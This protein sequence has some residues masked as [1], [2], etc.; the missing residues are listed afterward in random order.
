MA[1]PAVAASVPPL[2]PFAVPLPPFYPPPPVAPPQAIEVYEEIRFDLIVS[3]CAALASSIL[4]LLLYK[5]VPRVRRTPGWLMLRATVCEAVVSACFLAFFLYENG[6]RWIFHNR[7]LNNTPVLPLILLLLVGFE[8]MAHAWR[9]LIFIEIVAVYRNPFAP[10]RFHGLYPFFVLLTGLAAVFAIGGATGLTTGLTTRGGPPDDD[11]AEQAGLMTLGL[12][13][14]FVPFGLFVVVGFSLHAAVKL[15][16]ASANSHRRATRDGVPPSISFLAR[17]RVMRHGT[18]YLIWHGGQLCVALALV[19]LFLDVDDV[20]EGEPLSIMWHAL[21]VI[22][23]GRPALSLLGWLVIN[24]IAYLLCGVCSLTHWL[25]DWVDLPPPRHPHRPHL[26]IPGIRASG[27]SAAAPT[28]SSLPPSTPRSAVSGHQS[29]TPLGPPVGASE[30]VG[31]KEEMRFE[32]LYV[33]L[34][35]HHPC[36]PHLAS[37]YA[38]HCS[39]PD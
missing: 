37:S 15:L 24:D 31:F 20:H 23:C 33:P 35:L 22:V 19:M 27:S 28:D 25:R 10:D 1:Q 11:K 8:T 34:P 5:F 17:Q 12:A 4:L 2:A 9:L 21:A 6:P 30:E 26:T 7:E 36:Q 38:S 39:P 18:A 14:V 13:F 29:P 3:S 16:L 32:L